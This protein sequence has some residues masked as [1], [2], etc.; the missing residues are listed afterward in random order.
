M[1][2]SDGDRKIAKDIFACLSV[3]INTISLS[4]D[5]QVSLMRL[6]LVEKWKLTFDQKALVEMLN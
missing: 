4:R 6:R 3:L 1:L 5:E 2:V